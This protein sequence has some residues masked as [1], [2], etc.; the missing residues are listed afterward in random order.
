VVVVGGLVRKISEVN[1]NFAICI[2]ELRKNAE[3]QTKQNNEMV[4]G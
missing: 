4:R 3:L 2:K 1:N